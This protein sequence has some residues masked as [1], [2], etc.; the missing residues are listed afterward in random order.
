METLQNKVLSIET[1][2]TKKVLLSW[3]GP[4]DFYEIDFKDN[5]VMGGRYVF[6]DWGDYASIDLND[7]EAETIAELYGLAID[8]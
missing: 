7:D 5:E 2:T 8:F 1:I 6:Q 3:G 4:A